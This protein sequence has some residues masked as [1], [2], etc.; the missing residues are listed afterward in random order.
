MFTDELDI[1]LERA[2]PDLLGST[3]SIVVTKEDT[4]ILNRRR[5]KKN[6][7]RSAAS[8]SEVA[9]PIVTVL[10]LGST[11]RIIFNAHNQIV[12]IFMTY[13]SLCFRGN[14]WLLY[15]CKSVSSI[16]L[17]SPLTANPPSSSTPEGSF[18]S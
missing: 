3:G 14:A 15:Q 13:K 11:L 7:P 5:R 8:K 9:S 6:Q 4:I 2:T 1:K 12:M 10:C 17:S 18:S 16:V